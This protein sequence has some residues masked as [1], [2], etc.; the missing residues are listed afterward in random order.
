MRCPIWQSYEEKCYGWMLYKHTNML[1]NEANVVQNL[2]L[3]LRR[4]RE[5][6]ETGRERESKETMNNNINL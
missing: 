3:V 4:E 2:F 1:L 6:G 5:R